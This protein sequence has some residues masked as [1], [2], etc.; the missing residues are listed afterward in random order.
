MSRRSSDF[1]KVIF[2][3][4]ERKMKQILWTTDV[5]VLKCFRLC[6]IDVSLNL[7]SPMSRLSYSGGLVKL[8]ANVE[9]IFSV[10]SSFSE[11]SI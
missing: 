11:K 3:A 7:R 6:D 8:L 2:G 1:G 5:L 9:F 4:N 10:N